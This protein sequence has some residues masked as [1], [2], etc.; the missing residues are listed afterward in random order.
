MRVL[1]ARLEEDREKSFAY[2][3][4]AGCDHVVVIT[5]LWFNLRFKS[6]NVVKIVREATS[7]QILLALCF[8]V[9]CIYGAVVLRL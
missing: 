2:K 1:L 3:P 9:E 6:L 7:L 8:E 5:T 4:V